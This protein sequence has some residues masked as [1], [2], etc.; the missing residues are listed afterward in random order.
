MCVFQLIVKRE[1]IAAVMELTPVKMHT[2][3]VVT[4]STK[5]RK[6]H[7]QGRPLAVAMQQ[8]TALSTDRAGALGPLMRR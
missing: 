5:V 4:A 7:Q 2:A 3:K 6:V 8:R 1:T